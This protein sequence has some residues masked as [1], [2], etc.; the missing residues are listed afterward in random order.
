M[1]KWYRFAM[2]AALIAVIVVAVR[3]CQSSG[4]T[5]E[6]IQNQESAEQTEAELTLKDVTL[7]QPDESG[8]LLW[9]VKAKEA[10]YSPDRRLA[11]L[12]S[13]EGE[14]FQDGKVIYKVKANQGEIR[15]NGKT[16]FLQ[17]NIV[18]NSPEENVTL[19]GNSL[20]WTPDQD[21]LLVR[22]SIIGEH[23]QLNATAQEAR[24]FNKTKRL[25]LFKGVVATTKQEPWIGFK[26]EKLILLLNEDKLETDTPLLMERY[27]SKTDRTVTDRLIGKQGEFDLTKQQA[28]LQ[29]QVQLN[30]LKIPLQT[31]SDIAV[32]SVKEGIVVIDKPV[33]IQQNKLAANANK[34]RL[35]LNTQ[36]LVLNGNA[37]AAS[38]DKQS[39]LLAD[40]LTWNIKTQDVDGQGNVSYSQQDPAATVTGDR[41]V[42]NLEQQTV[43]VTGKD[44]ITEIVPVGIE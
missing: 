25:E 29:Q 24:L 16:I 10:T 23:P 39:L 33:Q 38:K 19:K 18:A 13:P 2:I 20:E 32:W 4:D 26:S 21:L 42:G 22:D 5:L 6:S 3:T 12:Q 9:R 41:A 8:G 14:L 34:G 17:G 30:A 1:N 43:V 28:I 40:Q 15:E 11:S 27:V 31:N 44:V 7:E 36:I 37:Q 35:N